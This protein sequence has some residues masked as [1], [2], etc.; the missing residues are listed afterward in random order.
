MKYVALLLL[1][2]TLGCTTTRPSGPATPPDFLHRLATLCGRAY[3]GTVVYPAGGKDPFAGKEL[4]MRV[5]TCSATEVRVPFEV[6]ADHSRTWVF[7]TSPQGLLLKHD[8]RHPDGTPDSITQYGG[9]AKA[10]GTAFQQ[11]F[12]ADTYTAQ[13]LPAAATN[14]WE[15]VLSEDLTTFSYR[16]HKDGKLRF[17]ADFDLTK[18][19]AR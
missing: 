17:Q 2:L 13:L 11:R 4:I 14:E 6:G 3:R 10:G 8:H 7:S 5:Q 1:L 15:T 18:P 19:L 9:F 16:L 12:P